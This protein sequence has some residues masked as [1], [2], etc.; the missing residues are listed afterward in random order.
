VCAPDN[1]LRACMCGRLLRA[2]APSPRA[3]ADPGGPAAGF[4][5]HC[6]EPD[7]PDEPVS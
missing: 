6:E 3:A 1:P 2:R 5:A 4:S 7:D